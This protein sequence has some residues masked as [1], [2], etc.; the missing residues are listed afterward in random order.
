MLHYKV[1]IITK[2]KIISNPSLQR[3]R[4]AAFLTV[5]Q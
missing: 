4:F 5:C 2:F 3:Q 1:Q